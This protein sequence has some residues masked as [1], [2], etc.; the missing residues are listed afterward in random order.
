[1]APSVLYPERVSAHLAALTV[2]LHRLAV[3][4]LHGAEHVAE[5]TILYL[6]FTEMDGK[7]HYQRLIGC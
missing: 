5:T 7:Q 3:H 2:V 4:G 6:Q 1:M